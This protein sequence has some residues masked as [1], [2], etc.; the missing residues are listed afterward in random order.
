MNPY[1]LMNDASF[2][3]TVRTPN[4]NEQLQRLFMEEEEER[5]RRQNAKV[6]GNLDAMMTG[7][8][9]QSGGPSVPPVVGSLDQMLSQQGAMPPRQSQP[10]VGQISAPSV[11]PTVPDPT[12]PEGFKIWQSQQQSTP[13]QLAL[14]I[15]AQ[16]RGA[17]NPSTSRG[18]AMTYGFGNGELSQG[19]MDRI[20]STR[21]NEARR[22]LTASQRRQVDTPIV[23]SGLQQALESLGTKEEKMQR[24]LRDYQKVGDRL[25]RPGTRTQAFTRPD[26]SVVL[27]GGERAS[28]PQASDLGQYIADVSDETT[29]RMA[30]VDKVIERKNKMDDK[31]AANRA[32]AA[33]ENK[34]KKNPA[35]AL[36]EP[37]N[38]AEAGI[39]AVMQAV[40]QNKLLD[41]ES[42]V[43]IF[44]AA[45]DGFNQQKALDADLAKQKLQNQGFANSGF[46]EI[47][48]AVVPGLMSNPDGSFASPEEM[49]QRLQQAGPLIAAIQSMLTGEGGQGLTLPQLGDGG[50]VSVA[51]P[52]VVKEKTATMTIPQAEAWMTENQYPPE[53]IQKRLRE[54]EKTATPKEREDAKVKIGRRKT[55]KDD[56]ISEMGD[57][58]SIPYGM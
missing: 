4:V 47:M 41:K 53:V 52:P 15:K 14:A 33:A 11:Q 12:S 17:F 27:I 57:P 58:V 51:V 5:R 45:R 28:S 7:M 43:A 10:M 21:A 30:G 29:R 40:A 49:Q 3:E 20:A 18:N 48:K 54:M 25:I 8:S 37:K 34:L 44:Q 9:G 19:A 36:S 24:G 50:G 1:G 2:G 6:I 31:L 55:N 13:S 46:G 35:M 39:Q 16:S 42:R 23:K 26:G 22:G 38:A 32:L 56:Q